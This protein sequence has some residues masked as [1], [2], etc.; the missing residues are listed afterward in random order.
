MYPQQGLLSQTVKD[1]LQ[2]CQVIILVLVTLLTRV[3]YAGI[4]QSIFW[5]QGNESMTVSDPGLGA[6]DNPGHVATDTVGKRMNGMSQVCVYHPVTS[7][8]LLGT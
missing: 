5:Q 3:R 2:C 6:L 8:T 1:L 7:Q 4:A